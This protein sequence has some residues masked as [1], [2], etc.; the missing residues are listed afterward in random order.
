SRKRPGHLR[1]GEFSIIDDGSVPHL[2]CAESRHPH[3]PASA[4]RNA[5]TRAPG[6]VMELRL[7]QPSTVNHRIYRG[8]R[9]LHGRC[10]EETLPFALLAPYRD[11]WMLPPICSRV[12]LRYNDKEVRAA[13]A[14]HVGD[15]VELGSS[16]SWVVEAAVVDTQPGP[17]VEE[18]RPC[19]L[20]LSVN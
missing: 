8:T 19:V 6:V 15:L 11:G 2:Q 17:P 12:R 7:H 18:A 13:V 5:L 9:I 10:G 14:L 3:G 4:H 16:K 1:A 20:T